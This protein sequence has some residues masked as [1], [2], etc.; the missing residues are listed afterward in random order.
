MPCTSLC[1]SGGRLMRRT[2]PCTRIIG[3]RPEDR[4]RS[5]AL[6]LT[7]KASNSEM[8]IYNPCA[9]TVCLLPTKMIMSTIAQ[10]LQAV[11]ASI[12]A[13][14]NAAGRP[15]ES[16]HLLAVSKTFGP[17]AVLEAAAAG[18]RA[19]GE[20]YLQEALDKMAA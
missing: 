18:Q 11:H 19:F 1:S 3:G 17:Q 7:E 14:A 20:N 12:V 13:A 15:P 6:F 5:E 9:T 2:S 16:V 4:C 10:K 8:S